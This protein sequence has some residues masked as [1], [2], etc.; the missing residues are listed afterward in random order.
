MMRLTGDGVLV[1]RHSALRADATGVYRKRSLS[2][3]IGWRKP[4][5]GDLIK[6]RC[7][8]IGGVA[9]VPDSAN[10]IAQRYPQAMFTHADSIAPSGTDALQTMRPNTAKSAQLQII[11]WFLEA[12]WEFIHASFGPVRN[13]YRRPPSSDTEAARDSGKAQAARRVK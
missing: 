12:G 9:G 10:G 13:R 6:Q 8:H 1:R 7:D 2:A 5:W 11:I 3:T 4:T